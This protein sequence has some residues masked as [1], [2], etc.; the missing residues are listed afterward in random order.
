MNLMR[1]AAL[2]GLR[3][4]DRQTSLVDGRETNWR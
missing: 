1:C 4:G 2:A 3:C